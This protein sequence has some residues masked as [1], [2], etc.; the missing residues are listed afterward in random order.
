MIN[1]TLSRLAYL[2]FQNEP[3]IFKNNEMI[4]LSKYLEKK[5]KKNKMSELFLFDVE[6]L[7]D[8]YI[9]DNPD[10]IKLLDYSITK[11][12]NIIVFISNL[13]LF[14]K[15]KDFNFIKNSKMIEFY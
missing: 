14:L 7:A 10:N 5:I 8:V 2:H 6:I 15:N 9:N 3:I 13:K 4:E 12:E 11:R 1:L